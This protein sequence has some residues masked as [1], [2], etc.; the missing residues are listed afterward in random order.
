MFMLIVID[1]PALPVEGLDRKVHQVARVRCSFCS[2]NVE[3]EIIEFGR[4]DIQSNWIRHRE[5]ITLLRELIDC[6]TNLPVNQS[7]I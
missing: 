6:M 3:L 4:V 5:M 2:A 1:M 7:P